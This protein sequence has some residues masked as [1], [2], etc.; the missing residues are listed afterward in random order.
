MPS[1]LEDWHTGRL[2]VAHPRMQDPNFRRTVVLVVEHNGEGAVGV[3]LNRPSE[4]AAAEIVAELE[5]LA[6]PP[7]MVFVGGPVG[8]SAAICLARLRE[9]GG[10]AG[11]GHLFGTVGSVDLDA[12]LAPLAAAVEGVR[13]F[14]GYA[15][16]AG[17]Q[18]EAEVADGGWFV[19]NRAD[20]D[21]FDP[22]PSRLWWRVLRRQRRRSLAILASYPADIGT[23]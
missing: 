4:M 11:V 1:M 16:W 9:A 15:G 18:L 14:A 13:L 20:D 7:G 5:T 8:P 23:N 2:L 3:V 21:V 17:G 6:L 19:V 12:D 22:D 10:S